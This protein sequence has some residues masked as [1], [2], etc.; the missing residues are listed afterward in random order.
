MITNEIRGHSVHLALRRREETPNKSPQTSG[1]FICS[2][3]PS[4][5]LYSAPNL[6]VCPASSAP[7]P[8]G[9]EHHAHSCKFVSIRPFL[10]LCLFKTFRPF[11]SIFPPFSASRKKSFR[12]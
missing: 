2:H 4:D 6:H 10:A 8:G 9:F 12:L 7:H 1:L 11:S 5:P 3:S